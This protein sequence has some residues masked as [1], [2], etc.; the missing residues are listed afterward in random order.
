[1]MNNLENKLVMQ[2]LQLK[3]L[4]SASN[5]SLVA[6]VLL[7]AI[8]AYMQHDVVSSSVVFVWF[9]LVV[10][11]TLARAILVIT[12]Q[13]SQV[14]EGSAIHTRVSR[15]RLG[16]L[17]GGL[18]WGSAGF[19]MFPVNDPQHQMFLIFMLAGLT[20][21]G[22]VSYSVDLICAIGFSVLALVPIII[23][24]FAGGDSLSVAMG[25]AGLLYLGFMI[26]VMRHTNRSILDNILLRHRAMVREE[27][28]RASEER[29]R[30]QLNHSPVGIFHYDT[31]FVITYCN[32]RFAEILHN[33]V[34]HLVGLNMQALKDQ[35]VLPALRDG[36]HGNDGFYEGQYHATLSDVDLWI[37]MTCAPSRDGNDSIIG[38][39]AIVHDISERK[40]AEDVLRTRAGELELHNHTLFQINQNAPLRTTMEDAV[41]QIEALNPGMIIAVCLLDKDGKTLHLGAAPSMPDFYNQA[42]DGIEIKDGLGSCGTAAYRGERI[43]VEDIQQHPYWVSLHDLASQAG[44]Q[45][46]WAQP[47][48]DKDGRVLGV[49]AVYHHNP[50][51]PTQSELLLIE[52]Y[53][54][55]IQVVI[56]RYA[57]QNE[58]RIAATAFETRDGIAVTDS[59]NEILQV[60]HAF[61]NITGYSAEEVVGRDPKMLSS[62]RHDADFYV[63]MWE[64]IINTGAWEGE[65]WN[66]RKNGEIYPEYLTISAVRDKD[67]A[68]VNY[69]STFRDITVSKAAEEE[70]KHLAFYDSLTRLPN[71]R[72]LV[73]RL[74][75][76]LASSARSG[77]KGALLFL[78]LDN[79]KSLNDTLGHDI[80]DLLLQQVAQRISSCVREVDTVARLGGDEFVVMLEDLSADTVEAASQAETVSEKILTVLKRPYQLD[81]H[82][83][84]STSSVGSTLFNGQ[85]ET[86]DE[87]MKQADIA[88]YQAKKAGGNILRFFYP[89]MQEI[90]NT[91]A[92]M[93]VELRKALDSRH[94]HLNYQIQVNDLGHPVGAEA[95]IRWIHPEHGLTPPNKFIP[96]AE[97]T[98]LI[99]PIGQWVLEAACKQLKEWSQN[100]VSRR[101]VLAVNVSAKQFHQ[102]DFV[103]QVQAIVQ[104]HAINPMLLKL[105]LTESLLLED[106]KST[107]KKMNALNQIGIHFTLDDFGTGYSSL[108]YLKQLPLDQL[109]IDQTF[110]RD[111]ATDT[112]DKAIVRTI[113]AM[114]K[115]LSLDVIAEGVE[116]GDQQQILLDEGCRHYQG[117]L[118]GKPMPIEQFDMLLN[119]S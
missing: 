117:Y 113:I 44:V 34:D 94:F 110:V 23:R 35:S 41:L 10:L 60:N 90:I 20:A 103:T 52:H 28:L 1:M 80:G 12:Y 104:H 112:S 4:L 99:L 25:M 36:L 6:G 85:Q 84:H 18:V 62:N 71:R 111:I 114:A 26:T 93:E 24:L 66:Q 119:K 109:K 95:L 118:F 2:P 91:R 67:G 105:E 57:A 37:E 72:F 19:L 42:I 86:T 49:F 58:L 70:I 31:N 38:G 47:F 7:A 8:L 98:G 76:A 77:K 115:S 14:G 56:E 33:S 89:Q 17:S 63:A 45:S 108:Q 61:T 64:S 29:H 69:V 73:D 48:K 5:T 116:T 30:L 79:F 13:R 78:D 3:Q 32:D 82:K 55:L 101:L 88:M 15:F 46:C 59:N 97:E 54:N 39:I 40:R 11:V 53:A 43:I 21:G 27:A 92:V 16:V 107:I 81:K 100:E 51:L 22:V 74:Q 102:N 65:V 83:H 9:S 75:R 106:I 87:L 96:L 50:S 68:I